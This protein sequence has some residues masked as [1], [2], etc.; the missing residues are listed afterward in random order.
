M[1]K[2]VPVPP[3]INRLLYGAAFACVL[4]IV[5]LSLLPAEEMPRTG[6]PDGTDHFIAY[7]GTGGLM[8]LA[9]R[10][11]GAVLAL[12]GLALVGLGGLMEVLQ[13][14]SPGRSTTWSD[15][16]M[17][18]GGALAGLLMGTIA[19]RII[20]YGRRQYSERLDSLPHL[21]APMPPTP[22]PVRRGR[23]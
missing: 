8:A 5:V 14:L 13:Q 15:F 7:W 10:G 11:R 6:I 17:S 20:S 3:A 12:A 21:G 19:A 16:L 22:A 2:P 4:I 18:G 9:F 23:P 1:N